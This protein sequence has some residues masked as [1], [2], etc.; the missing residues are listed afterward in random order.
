M[1]N[2][3][4]P[5]VADRIIADGVGWWMLEGTE[6]QIG[7]ATLVRHGAVLRE[8]RDAW[9][10]TRSAAMDE[11]AVRIEVIAARLSKQAAKIRQEAED[12]RRKEVVE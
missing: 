5:M 4:I 10:E 6:V 12:I 1:S 3:Y 8:D 11:A 2:V 7:D 9:H